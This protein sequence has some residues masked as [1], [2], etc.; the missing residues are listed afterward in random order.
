MPQAAIV[1]TGGEPPGPEVL[2]GLPTDPLV[3]AADSGLDHARRLGV[4][5]DVAVGDFDSVDP[6]AL[7]EARVTGTRIESHPGDKD[8]TDLELAL[9]LACREGV[10]QVLV[11]GGHGGRVDH[12][13]GNVSVWSSPAYA[14]MAIEARSGR[15]RLFVVRSHLDLTG[16]PGEYVSLVPWNGPVDGVTTTG[17]RW[18]LSNERLEVGS[19][20]GISN[21]MI[22][23][24]AT[25]TMSDGVLLVIA[26]GER[27]VDRG[28]VR[29]VT[30]A[31]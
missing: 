29:R 28:A 18:A 26:P 5:V 10:T 2:E 23:S 15:S 31:A 14:T 6:S 9:D 24:D 8:K 25:V 20:R 16:E 13:L 1:F 27:H 21:E 30:G 19:S 7:E 3:V 22:L 12:W 11:V 4:A 17:L